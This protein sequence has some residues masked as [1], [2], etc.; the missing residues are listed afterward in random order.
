MHNPIIKINLL[1]IAH[2]TWNVRSLYKAG[3]LVT[4]SKELSKYTLDLVG[5]QEDQMGGP[6]HRTSR[7]IQ[8]FYEKGNENN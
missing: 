1:L 3:S 7:R 2:W 8:I 5:V 4:V 6:W